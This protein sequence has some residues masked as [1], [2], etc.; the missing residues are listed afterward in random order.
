MSSLKSRKIGTSADCSI[1][2]V[3][4]ETG[5]NSSFCPLLAKYVFSRISLAIDKHTLMSTLSE[6]RMI[7]RVCNS[8]I[9]CQGEG[10]LVLN[11][12]PKSESVS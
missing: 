11:I 4:W 2:F 8:E 3:F 6:S 5:E 7:P 10:D 12:S 9:T 1:V